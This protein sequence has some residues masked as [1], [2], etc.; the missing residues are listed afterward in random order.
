MA[1]RGNSGGDHIIGSVGP[2]ARVVVL[3]YHNG[4]MPQEYR[5]SNLG[6]CALTFFPALSPGASVPEKQLLLEPKKSQTIIVEKTGEGK[7]WFLMAY[8]SQEKVTGWYEMNL[9]IK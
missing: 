1:G 5:I 3:E 7:S 9:N 4:C 6:S 2:G 8:N